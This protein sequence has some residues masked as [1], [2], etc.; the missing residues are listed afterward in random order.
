MQKRYWGFLPEIQPASGPKW[1]EN[2]LSSCRLLSRS[3]IISRSA[4][5]GELAQLVER[6][7]RKDFLEKR[8]LISQT[9]PSVARSGQTP[10]PLQLFGGLPA[11]LR[12]D[13]TGPKATELL[14]PGVTSGGDELFRT[15]KQ[16]EGF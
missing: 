15:I 2:A 14:S 16:P 6:L 8:L 10:R 9:T 11:P 1:T 4:D 3:R 13:S 5:H 7:V 12:L